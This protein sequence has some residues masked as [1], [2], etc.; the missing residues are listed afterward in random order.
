M[1]ENDQPYDLV[2]DLVTGER[3][4]S[5]K[6]GAGSTVLS[7]ASILDHMPNLVSKVQAALKKGEHQ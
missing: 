4:P 1:D 3:G 7:L 5:L 6:A 2:L